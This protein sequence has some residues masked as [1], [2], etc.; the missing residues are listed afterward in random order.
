MLS[1]LLCVF[2]NCLLDVREARLPRAQPR[3]LIARWMQRKMLSYFCIVT[4]AGESFYHL[5]AEVSHWV[6]LFWWS[7]L[8][9]FS[10]CYIPVAGVLFLSLEEERDF[11]DCVGSP[12]LPPGMGWNLLLL[13]SSLLGIAPVTA[14]QRLPAHCTNCRVI[15][16]GSQSLDLPPVLHSWL[17]SAGAGGSLKRPLSPAPL[18]HLAHNADCSCWFWGLPVIFT[19]D[20]SALRFT[21]LWLNLLKLQPG[22]NLRAL[23]HMLN[24]TPF[25]C[26]GLFAASSAFYIMG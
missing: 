20:L 13:K 23:K 26:L 4:G 2:R 3:T 19:Y 11:P 15:K 12:L 6:N 22:S 14:E 10:V 18:R 16:K 8:S 9:C 25:I 7:R 1:S 21:D 17:W 24:F 5:Q